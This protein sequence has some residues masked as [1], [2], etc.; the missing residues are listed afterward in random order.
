MLDPMNLS[1][2]RFAAPLMLLLLSFGCA[3]G[4]KAPVAFDSHYEQ[5]NAVLAKYT[6]PAG[7]N[8]AGLAENPAPL[9]AALSQM[10]EVPRSQFESWSN[11]AQLA[12]LVNAHNAGLL[13]RIVG[14]WPTSSLGSTS[15]FW[16]ARWRND[17][18]LM[19]RK[20]SLRELERAALG[21]KYL[22]S[23]SIF[24]I[25]RG[26]RGGPRLPPVALTEENLNDLADRQT[27]AFLADPA[28]M[29]YDARNVQIRLSKVVLDRR[30]IIERDYTTLWIFLEKYLPPREAAWLQRRAPRI[31]QLPYDGDLDGA[32]PVTAAEAPATP[33]P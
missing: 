13:A 7:V 12:F 32:A 21:P 18:E 10:A 30:A 22:D 1:L 20:W 3:S 5:F 4:P 15:W 25:S 6:S 14:N 29:D 27:R 26:E 31:R 17:I 28:N 9:D 23:R 11:R 16:P 33:A 19:G 24:L 2:C 8:Y